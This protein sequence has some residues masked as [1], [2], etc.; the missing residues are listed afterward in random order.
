MAPPSPKPKPSKRRPKIEPPPFDV[1]GLR[2]ALVELLRIAA[3]WEEGAEKPRSD[4]EERIRARGE[5]ED[6][7]RMIYAAVHGHAWGALLAL[8]HNA[9]IIP[10]DQYLVP[11]RKAAAAELWRFKRR[12]ISEDDLV[13]RLRQIIGED[14]ASADAIR[15]LIGLSEVTTDGQIV[16]DVREGIKGNNGPQVAAGKLITHFMGRAGRFTFAA[17]QAVREQPFG[18][19]AL[20][21]RSRGAVVTSYGVPRYVLQCLG[22]YSEEKIEAAITALHGPKG[23]PDRKARAIRSKRARMKG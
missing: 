5:D 23:P 2:G 22:C 4:A 1:S 13:A 10:Y 17:E 21:T 11:L 19:G 15:N 16:R 9:Q 20:L 3:T 12:E 7:L 8:S 18:G 6:F 14:R